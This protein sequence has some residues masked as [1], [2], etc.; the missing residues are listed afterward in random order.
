MG[1]FNTYAYLSVG[2]AAEACCP[3]LSLF[4]IKFLEIVGNSFKTNKCVMYLF[5][6]I[7]FLFV[8]IMLS[9]LHTFSGIGVE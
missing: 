8:C 2:P 3:K 6:N 5:I 4:L 7:L 9:I 1:D